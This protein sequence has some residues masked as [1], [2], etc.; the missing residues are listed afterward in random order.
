[1]SLEHSVGVERVDVRLAGAPGREAEAE[2]LAPLLDPVTQSAHP[3]THGAHRRGGGRGHGQLGAAPAFA[4]DIEARGVA[5][6]WQGRARLKSRH[7][8]RQFTALS[9]DFAPA[10]GVAQ[11]G[12]E[13]LLLLDDRLGDGRRGRLVAEGVGRLGREGAGAG[14]VVEDTGRSAA[15]CRRTAAGATDRPA[16]ARPRPRPAGRA[17]RPSSP[18]PRPPRRA[19]TAGLSGLMVTRRS[20]STRMSRLRLVEPL[21]GHPRGGQR[22]VGELR[23]VDGPGHRVVAFLDRHEL[24]T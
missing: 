16:P 11:L 8:L 4:G 5:T 21:A 17:G 12:D 20:R 10:G 9:Q 1:M 3:A 7:V 24:D 2:A 13:P 18:R 14:L 6:R 23:A 15:A 22:E 19:P